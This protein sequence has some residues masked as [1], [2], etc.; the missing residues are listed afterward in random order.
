MSAMPMLTRFACPPLM[1]FAAALPIFTSLHCD[2]AS[3]SSSWSTASSFSAYGS[4]TGRFS[5]AV[6]MS[7]CCVGSDTSSCALQRAAEAAACAR[8][9]DGQD[10]EQ[11]VELLHVA[12]S[13]RGR[14]GRR[15]RREAEGS[16][17]R[18]GRA[19]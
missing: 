4:D 6:Y 8:L 19:R 5:S 18:R 10:A 3:F 1:P 14:G 13:D 2:S 17:W 15:R 12:A 16:E 7:I 11:R 9:L